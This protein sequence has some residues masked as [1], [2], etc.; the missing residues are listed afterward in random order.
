MFSLHEKLLA[1]ARL[2]DYYVEKRQKKK[3]VTCHDFRHYTHSASVPVWNIFM[4]DITASQYNNM[5]PHILVSLPSLHFPSLCR[6]FVSASRITVRSDAG[7]GAL[8]RRR[9]IC[10]RLQAP[11]TYDSPALH[12]DK[13]AKPRDVTPSALSSIRRKLI[14]LNAVETTQ[15]VNRDPTPTPTRK[16]Q[17][18]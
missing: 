8:S 4:L 10:L 11:G 15:F 6:P 12:T 18:A 14:L 5:A 7:C 3:N 2:I 16:G 17:I 1:T 13:Q 9:F